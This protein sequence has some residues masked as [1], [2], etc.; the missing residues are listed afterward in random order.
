MKIFVTGTSSGIGEALVRTYLSEGHEVW[1]I[2]RRNSKDLDNY[3]SFHFLSFDLGDLEKLEDHILP[4]LEGLKSLDLVILNAGMLG[5]IREMRET[6]L[7]EIQKVMDVNLWANKLILDSLFKKIPTIHQLVA[8][9]SGASVNV[10]RGWNAYAL[11]KAALN[12]LIRLYA[13]ELPETHFSALAP[14]IIDTAMQDHIYELPEDERFPSLQKL[15]NAK[16]T[17]KMPG[18][19]E[20]AGLLRKAFDRVMEYESGAFVDVRDLYFK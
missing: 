4:F 14:G 17:S 13:A 1:G 20:S 11:S 2:S 5:E 3:G 12:M 7:A 10:N 19:E 16:G 18:P 6:P 15:K 9:S 8:I